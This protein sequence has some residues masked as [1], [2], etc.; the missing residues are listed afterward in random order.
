MGPCWCCHAELPAWSGGGGLGVSCGD[1]VMAWVTAAALDVDAA[2]ATALWTDVAA[3]V[4]RDAGGGVVP[5]VE[6]RLTCGCT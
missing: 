5:A 2:L 4:W 1:T 3:A 6:Q